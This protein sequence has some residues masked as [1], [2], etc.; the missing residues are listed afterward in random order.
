[1]AD[2]TSG[3]FSFSKRTTNNIQSIFAFGKGV[4]IF[5]VECQVADEGCCKNVKCNIRVNR[6]DIYTDPEDLHEI[7][8]IGKTPFSKEV[9]R[10]G[11]PFVFGISCDMPYK[12]EICQ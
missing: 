5:F 10:Y 1:M 3:S 4:D 7:E 6:E 8:R 11:N 9:N 12:S 2:T